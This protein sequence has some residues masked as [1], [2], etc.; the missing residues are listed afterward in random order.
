MKI[1]SGI[2]TLSHTYDN[3]FGKSAGYTNLSETKKEEVA[4]ILISAAINNMPPVEIAIKEGIPRLTASTGLSALIHLE[5]VL[6]SGT[7]RLLV[8]A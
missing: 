5:G 3:V 2:N 1:E 4:N 6:E 8:K 7:L